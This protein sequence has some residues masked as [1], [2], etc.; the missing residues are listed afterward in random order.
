MDTFVD[1]AWYYL[2]YL[3]PHNESKPF[4]REEAFEWIPVDMYIGGIE[5]A[6]A[7]LLY[8]RFLARVLADMD[9]LPVRE[10]FTNLFTQGMICK[11][12]AKMSKSIGN[13]VDPCYTVVS[14]FPKSCLP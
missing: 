8:S 3:T 1:S 9:L 6:I 2:R 7:H 5:H 11:D 13:V 4:G 14:K 12:G 10:P